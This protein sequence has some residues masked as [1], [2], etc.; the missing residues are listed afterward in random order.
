MIH[1]EFN[2]NKTRHHL[3]FIAWFKQG[4][5]YIADGQVGRIVCTVVVAMLF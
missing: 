2:G 4:T 5:N 3:Q 1:K